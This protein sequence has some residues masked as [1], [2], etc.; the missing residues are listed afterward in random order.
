MKIFNLI[1][2]ALAQKE[3][4]E[5]NDE[6]KVP[7]RHP[8]QRLNVRLVSKFQKFI[9]ISNMINSSDYVFR[10]YFTFSKFVAEKRNH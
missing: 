2:L 8:I 1:G 9:L 3:E 6:R 5:K 7:D 4:T 10:I